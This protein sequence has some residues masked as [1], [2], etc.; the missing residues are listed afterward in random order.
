[1]AEQL[2]STLSPKNAG[3]A[4]HMRVE[5]T[6]LK[7]RNLARKGLGRVASWRLGDIVATLRVKVELG[8]DKLSVVIGPLQSI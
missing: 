4:R 8:R 5:L 7:T 3:Y 1:M 6:V 2:L